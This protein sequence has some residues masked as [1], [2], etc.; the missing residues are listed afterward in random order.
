MPHIGIN[1]LWDYH[2]APFSW[3]EDMTENKLDRPLVLCSSQVGFLSPSTTLAAV[4]SAIFKC[5]TCGREF[6]IGYQLEMH[7]ELVH[8]S[9][10]PFKCGKCGQEFSIKEQF[11]NHEK[12]YLHDSADSPKSDYR[13]GRPD[14]PPRKLY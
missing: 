11:E 4:D 12:H 5:N 7:T 8:N 14:V 1:Q 6:E 3:L 2:Q 10:S 13:G 9:K